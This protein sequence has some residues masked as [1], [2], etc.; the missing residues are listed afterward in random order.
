[1]LAVAI[2]VLAFVLVAAAPAAAIYAESRSQK[3]A[4]VPF[5]RRTSFEYI[6]ALLVFSA[7]TIVLPGILTWLGIIDFSEWV[8]GRLVPAR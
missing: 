3:R 8:P 6:M 2:V 7:L 1:M 5:R 4:G